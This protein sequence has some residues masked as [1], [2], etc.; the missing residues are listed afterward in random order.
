MQGSRLTL[1]HFTPLVGFVMPNSIMGYGC[2]I[3]QSCSAGSTS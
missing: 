2:L 1:R 3:P